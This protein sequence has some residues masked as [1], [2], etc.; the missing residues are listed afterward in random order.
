M[1]MKTVKEN[2]EDSYA[3]LYDIKVTLMAFL[4]EKHCKLSFDCRLALVVTNILNN[5]Y[6]NAQMVW[7]ELLE[8]LRTVLI[9]QSMILLASQT[10]FS[11]LG[12]LN[13]WECW[14]K[15]MSML[16]TLWMTYLPR[17][18][19]CTLLFLWH[20]IL[21]MFMLQLLLICHFA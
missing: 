17:S 8:I 11:T 18:V 4:Y 16:V 6:R 21:I 3:R 19:I 13:F 12:C 5:Y 9:H 10:H 1:F 15:V 2:K 7:S 14:V 20:N